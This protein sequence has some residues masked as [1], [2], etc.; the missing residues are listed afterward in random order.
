MMNR[1]INNKNGF[2]LI[3]L[4]AVIVIMG[5]LMMVAIPAMTRYIENAKRDVFADTAKKYISAARYTLLSDGFQC[6]DPESGLVVSCGLS[7]LESDN[8]MFLIIPVSLIDVE[9][10]TK[11]SPWGKIFGE[12]AAVVVKNDGTDEKPNYVYS[13]FG[14]DTAGHGIQQPIAETDI[15]R[16]AV[17]NNGS[18]SYS[19]IKTKGLLGHMSYIYG[20]NANYKQVS[21]VN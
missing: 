1:K 14:V 6:K 8:K 19:T 11:K 9:N 4:L 17:L 12:Y 2:T 21:G 5:V 13:F 10:D 20:Q 7:D 3:E 15:S 16:A 18:S